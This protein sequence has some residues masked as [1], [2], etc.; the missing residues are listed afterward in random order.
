[1]GAPYWLRPDSTA[2]PPASLACDDPPGLL[3]VGGDLSPERLLT[4]YSQG[5][6]PWFNDDSP[7]LWWSPDPRMVLQPANVLV[8]R[9][10]QRFIRRH[11]GENGR[12]HVTMDEQFEAV[13]RHCAQLRQQR[14][15]TWITA[16]MQ[17]AYQSLHELGYAHSVEVWQRDVDGEQSLVGGLYGVAL[18]TMFFGESMFSLI[19][20]VSKLAFIALA[21]QLDRWNFT[22]IDCQLP[23]QHLASLG[24]GPMPREEFLRRLAENRA[25][26]PRVSPGHWVMAADLLA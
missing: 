20:D 11:C 14:E 21:R 25:L 8:S 19:P 18:G 10:M 26:Q 12:L 23:T 17:R 2:F 3:A 16:D 9:S 15:G 22:L 4:A 1:M 5:I 13:I 6:F 7:I 24:A